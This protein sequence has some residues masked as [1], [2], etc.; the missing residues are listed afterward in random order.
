[1]S[2]ACVTLKGLYPEKK[3]SIKFQT[4][5]FIESHSPAILMLHMFDS[6]IM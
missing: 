2:E 1:L 4:Q 3:N 6:C 5:Y